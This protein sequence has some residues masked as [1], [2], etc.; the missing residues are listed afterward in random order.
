MLQKAA[1]MSQ[2]FERTY[3]NKLGVNLSTKR[4]ED[5][6]SLIIENLIKIA[7][8]SDYHTLTESNTVGS[9]TSLQS[10]ARLL[11]EQY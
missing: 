6:A 2:E 11:L 7:A 1:A 10:R 5:K 3:G 8:T 9:L 4:W